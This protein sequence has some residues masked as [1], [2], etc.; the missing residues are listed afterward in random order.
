[1]SLRT[2]GKEQHQSSG[3]HARKIQCLRAR[4]C[5]SAGLG[6]VLLV[7]TACSRSDGAR[8]DEEAWLKAVRFEDATVAA[9]IDRA[10]QTY[11][12]AIA[13]F[14]D[15]SWLDLYIGNH[16]SGAVLLRNQHDGTF[17]DVLPGSGITPGGDQH[18]TGWADFDRDGHLDL[19]V[20]LGAGRGL[21][22][23]SNRLYRGDGNGRFEDVTARSGAIDPT[24]RS[25]AMAWLDVDRDGDVDLMVTNW[26]SPNR[27]F[28]NRGDGT[29]DDVSEAW[30][31]AALSG[32]RIAWGDYDGDG[33]P[34]VLLSGTPKGLRLLHNDAGTRF[35]DETR[36]AGLE[37]MKDP[38]QGMAFGDY[39]NDGDLDI[40]VS[41]GADFD[42]NVVKDQ[43]GT[44][45]FAFFAHEDPSGFDFTTSSDATGVELELYENGSPVAPD[46]IRCGRDNPA[47]PHF[48]CPATAVESAGQ[49]ETPAFLVWRDRD[50]QRDC[51]TCPA[52]QL[53]HLRW[54]GRGDHH[55]SGIV[56]TAQD[57]T[58]VGLRPNVQ[59]GA[60]LWRNDGGV[61]V[62]DLDGQHGLPGAARVNGQ[63]VQ[64]ADVDA[65]GWLDLYLVDSGVDGAPG[66][67]LL[68]LN[69]R[70]RRFVA[71]P[72]SAG[73]TP[74]S[75]AGRGVGAH[76]F[77]Y[78]RDGRLDLFLTN[79]WGAPPFDRGP[80]RLLHNVGTTGHWLAF[81]LRG[82]ASNRDGL[83][84][85]VLVD[86]CGQRQMRYQNGGTSYFSQSI[87]PVYF[88][89]GTCE[90]ADTV[91]IQWPSGK[92]QTLRDV[93]TD[94]HMQVEESH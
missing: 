1:M 77:D 93:S 30:G 37:P 85:V 82:H 50:E 92:R 53:W 65:D 76:F 55:L 38:I 31:I 87:V 46:R 84:A 47:S 14:D 41:H 75:G 2:L 68:L 13:D 51:D 43:A 28:L 20:A 32:T 71:V 73:A 89:L 33:F 35:T 44:L 80:Y 79:G 49:S 21:A 27:L 25:R 86:A 63:A 17:R 39:D 56:H 40:A 15:D 94:Q 23:K 64:W 60:A 58:P 72:A 5:A 36:A 10:T 52:R 22:T 70:G 62:R 91:E 78:D 7:A 83:G 59:R 88:G 66:S 34:D 57:A 69:D 4:A 42:E 61:F 16:A 74:D 11:D 9:G 8:A 19:Y 90:T 45:R 48:T 67:S 18:G 24:G 54:S 12:A 29:F 81:T 6:L 26:A 3:R